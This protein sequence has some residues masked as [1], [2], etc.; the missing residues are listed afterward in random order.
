[1]SVKQLYK[2][3]SFMRI[4]KYID[5]CVGFTNIHNKREQRAYYDAKSGFCKKFFGQRFINYLGPTYYN[6][7]LS[8]EV[9]KDAVQNSFNK[10][11]KLI[12]RTY[13]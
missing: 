2:K 6:N 10:T 13:E 5:D 12:F 9:K 4:I 8:L 11:H 1:M 3:I 7:S